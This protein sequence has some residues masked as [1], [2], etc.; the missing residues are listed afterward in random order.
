[1]Q[2][3]SPLRLDPAGDRL[4]LLRSNLTVLCARLDNDQILAL[5]DSLHALIR[6]RST[7][8]EPARRCAGRA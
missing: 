4:E 1:M 3:V 6:E 8:P 5:A 2:H 7:R